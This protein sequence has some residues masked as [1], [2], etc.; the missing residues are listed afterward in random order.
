MADAAATSVVIPAF[1]EDTAVGAVALALGIV[2]GF[3]NDVLQSRI[4]NGAVI[5]LMFAVMAFL[6][7][8]VSEQIATSRLQSSDTDEP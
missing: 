7:G 5:L 1:D 6:V 4:P 2:Y 3:G 8:L